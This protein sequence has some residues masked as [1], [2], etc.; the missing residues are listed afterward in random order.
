MTLQQLAA[1]PRSPSTFVLRNFYTALIKSDVFWNADVLSAFS[2]QLRRWLF[3]FPGMHLLG[4]L[5]R[6]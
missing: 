5:H 2:I 1:W 4:L 6:F 3:V